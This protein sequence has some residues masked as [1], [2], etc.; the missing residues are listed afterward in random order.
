MRV[1]I[2]FS[3]PPVAVAIEWML[4]GI[5]LP[6]AFSH[7]TVL[8]EQNALKNSRENAPISDVTNRLPTRQNRA[9]DHRQSNMIY[10]LLDEEN[11]EPSLENSV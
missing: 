4:V 3:N 11:S 8:S 7:N 10:P 6:A 5:D 1:L 2:V 9:S